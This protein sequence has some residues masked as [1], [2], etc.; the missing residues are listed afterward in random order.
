MILKNPD[1]GATIDIAIL[2]QKWFF[3]KGTTQKFP[4]E[5]GQVLKE[6]YGFLE[7]LNV[8]VK[9]A[10]EII[11]EGFKCSACEYQNKVKIGVLGHLRSHP[12]G[13]EVTEA[14]PIGEATRRPT[15]YEA[16]NAKT[17]RPDE[18]SELTRQYP[19]VE[20]YGEGFEERRS[21]RTNARFDGRI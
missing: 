13:I 2:G 5:V 6:R 1:N 14:K 9:A 11:P 16:R 3:P 10:V 19:Q 4:V 21:M 12:E 7:E 20:F 18:D 15:L 8:S 17:L